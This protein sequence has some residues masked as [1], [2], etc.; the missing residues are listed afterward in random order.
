MNFA[1]A[2]W[3]RDAYRV[4]LDLLKVQ[5][6]GL[7][8]QLTYVGFRFP[9]HLWRLGLPFV[10]GPIGG[11]ENTPWK[12]LPAMGLKGAVYYA[13]RNLINSAQRQWLRT[14]RRAIAAAGP[15]LI[16]A[17][18]GIAHELKRVY[19][20]DSTVISEVVAPLELSPAVPRAR[21]R[22]EPLKVVWSGLHLPGKALNLLIEALA[23]IEPNVP[24]E[25]NILGDG[26]LRK[27]WT[28]LVQRLGVGDRCIW[29]GMVSRHEALSIMSQAHVLAI[30]SLKDLT[31]T[32]L[33]E[34]LALGLPVICPDHCG[35]S[36]VVTAACGIKVDPSSVQSVIAGFYA[37][38][39]RLAGDEQ[40]RY[41]MAVSALERAR[42]YSRDALCEKLEDVYRRVL[43]KSQMDGAVA[44]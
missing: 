32:V 8:H 18:Q 27:Q 42:A 21:A 19:G 5:S 37:G 29:H 30:T 34:G 35:F 9:G 23:R 1:Y 2:R 4:A 6:F 39:L 16:A 7:A 12:L 36:N 28:S 14:P 41:G 22:K 20:A 13:G 44:E 38:I 43:S 26:P 33:L 40:A 10:W 24:I 25:L 15:G 17:T 31:S 3:Q 11:L